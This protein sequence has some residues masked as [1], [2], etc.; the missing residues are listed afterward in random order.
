MPEIG[1]IFVTWARKWR[2]A[3]MADPDYDPD[4]DL[5]KGCVGVLADI[6]QAFGL[7]TVAGVFSAYATD[8][9]WLFS[10][11]HQWEVSIDGTAEGSTNGA[12]ARKR[13]RMA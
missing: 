3:V 2:E 10:Q 1:R 12:L 6:V 7:E 9:Q 11:C 4:L 8:F 13:F 5:V